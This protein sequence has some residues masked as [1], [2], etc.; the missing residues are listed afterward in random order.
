[1]TALVVEIDPTE[2]GLDPRV[3]GALDRR[4]SD[5]VGERRLRG[6]LAVVARGGKIAHVARAGHRDRGSESPVD[7]DTIWRIYSMTK[8][9]TT[10]AALTL[11]ERGALDLDEPIST[12]IPSFET[13]RVYRGGA[14]ASPETAPAKEPMRV[15][16]LLTHTSGLT[17]AA[18]RQT[19]VDEMYRNAGFDATSNPECTLAEACELLA[20]IPLL[21]EPGAEWSYGMSSDVLGRVIEVASGM[22]L[23]DYLATAVLGP[24]GMGETGFRVVSEEHRRV[25]V[26]DTDDGGSAVPYE[27]GDVIPTT[28]PAYLSGGGG[29]HSVYTTASDYNRFQQMLLGN[30]RL[31]GVRIL[32]T[33][34][35]RLMTRNHL[36]GGGDLGSFGRLP[37]PGAPPAAG[38]GFGFGTWLVVD[39]A[40]AG[41]PC[42]A[43]T[44]RWAGAASTA[45]FVDYEK[46]LTGAFYAAL[47]PPAIDVRREYLELIYAALV[48]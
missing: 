10:V 5:W 18:F 40:S 35:V 27:H 42:S 29:L 23:D 16:H 1:L 46:G 36:P 41:E 7:D 19:A 45:C 22:G 15:R 8:P 34:T 32:D 4:M 17:Y 33:A 20:A 13:L 38:V 9:I 48:D 31:G 11:Y 21:H 24:L 6:A 3:L 12:F 26:L 47:F 28:S 25:A 30:G 39:P 43:G 44:A 14:A 2:A 37:Y